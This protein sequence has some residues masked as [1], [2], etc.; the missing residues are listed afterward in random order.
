MKILEVTGIDALKKSTK[1]SAKSKPI[2]SE[3]PRNTK[4]PKLK[5]LR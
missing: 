2:I 1:I 4:S 3:K 5:R